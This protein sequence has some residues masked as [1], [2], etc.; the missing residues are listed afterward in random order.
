LIIF[1]FWKQCHDCG[2]L[3]PIHEAKKESMLQDLVETA[4][5]PFEQGKS[6][7]GLGNK[8]TKN[9]YQKIRERLQE[10]IENEPKLDIKEEIRK[11]NIDKIID[12][13]RILYT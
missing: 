13:S 1:L 7:V 4:D 6:I 3:V 8:G 9:K 10:R 11:G 12:D 2:Q 5:N